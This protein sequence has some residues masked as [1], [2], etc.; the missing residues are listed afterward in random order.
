[1]PL[2]GATRAA[3]QETLLRYARGDEELRLS[4]ELTGPWREIVTDCLAR[5]HEGRAAH[6]AASLLRRAERAT[7]TSRAPRLPR[8]RPRR[9]GRRRNIAAAGT[10]GAAVL[11]ATAYLATAR[12]TPDSQGYERCPAGSVCFFNERNGKGE[13]CSWKGDDK[14]W[15]TGR[16]TCAWTRDSPVRSIFNNDQESKR[17]DAVAYY[18]GADWVPTGF[19]RTRPTRRTGCTSVNAQ[20]NL[21]GTYAPLSHRWVEHC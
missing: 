2:P 20:G 1:M 17:R 5:T 13:L 8:L 7:G 4:P 21:K 14:N 15:L 19:D 3:R 16:E 9:P 10:I 6:D 11:A 12:E 18:R